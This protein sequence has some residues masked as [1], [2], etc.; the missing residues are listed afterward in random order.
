MLEIKH[1]SSV[2]DLDQVVSVFLGHLDPDA[3]KKRIRIWILSLKT[4]PCY[5]ISFHFPLFTVIYYLEVNLEL[6]CVILPVEDQ[7]LYILVDIPGHPVLRG[8]ILQKY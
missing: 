7:H 8:V 6:V 1:F 5:N 2:A 4:D 3:V